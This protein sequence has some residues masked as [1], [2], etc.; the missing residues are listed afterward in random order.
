MEIRKMRDQDIE[1][2]IP[3][4]GY[5]LNRWNKYCFH[6]YISI[7]ETFILRSASSS[8]VSLSFLF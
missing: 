7:F 8:Q 6:L 2:T 1:G 5:T 3:D 4:K